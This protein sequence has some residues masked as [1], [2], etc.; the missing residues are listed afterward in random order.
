MTLWAFLGLETACANA[1]RVENPHKNIPRAILFEITLA[2][3]C[4]IVTTNIMFGIV[5]ASE[6]ANSSAPFGFV[7]KQ[8]F[9]G[10]VGNIIILLILI[11]DFGA[12][13]S[14]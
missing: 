14:W 3:L 8:M 11:N 7:F 13:V 6:L 9:N 1:E 12:L 4:Y 5:P 2:A 10:Y